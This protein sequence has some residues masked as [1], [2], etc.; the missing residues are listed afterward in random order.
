MTKKPMLCVCS[1]KGGI[2]LSKK[3]VGMIVIGQAH[4]QNEYGDI[5]ELLG[6]E[7]DLGVL[8]LL[9]GLTKEEINRFSP[10]REEEYVISTLENGNIVQLGSRHAHHLIKEKLELLQQL[11]FCLN[12]LFCTA[13]FKGREIL[14]LIQPV[15]VIEGIL[16]LLKVIKL[17]IIVPEESQIQPSRIQYEAFSPVV[18][19]ASPY[20]NK[21]D[22]LVCAKEF[23]ATDVE[24]ILTDC[25][26]FTKEIGDEIANL[27]G[28]KVLVPRFIVCTLVKAIA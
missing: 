14:N 4:K 27:S 16:Q 5:Y 8:G 23:K 10:N 28:K 19:H 20:G 24:Y 17:G 18:K 26:G 3:K 25:M 7:V 22:I 6:K 12:F 21:E 13:S 2:Q 11:G 1:M 15:E 9:D